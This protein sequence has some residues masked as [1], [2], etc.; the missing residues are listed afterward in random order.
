MSEATK[1]PAAW[2]EVL[3]YAYIRTERTAEAVDL[4]ETLIAR[5]PGEAR[6]WR[7]L[8]SIYL[9]IED[10]QGGAAGLAVAAELVKDGDFADARRLAR[11]FG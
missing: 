10:M 7:Q 8:A 6:W 3:A 11:L 2:L 1:P 9:L 4:L 5:R